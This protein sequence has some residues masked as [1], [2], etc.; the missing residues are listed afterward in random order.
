M[1]VLV[2]LKQLMLSN[3]CSLVAFTLL[4][5]YTQAIILFQGRHAIFN[6]TL[7]QLKR[8]TKE[9]NELFF[10]MVCICIVLLFYYCN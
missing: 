2:L 10:L 8:S 4:L 9:K 6:A 7:K 3:P 1:A 5:K